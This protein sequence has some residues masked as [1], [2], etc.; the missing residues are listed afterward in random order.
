[1]FSLLSPGPSLLEVF[2]HLHQTWD[3]KN[4]GCAGSETSSCSFNIDSEKEFDVSSETDLTDPDPPYCR[5]RR[6][7]HGS[8]PKRSVP[9]LLP[10]FS[11]DSDDATDKDLS[12]IPRDYVQSKKPCFKGKGFKIVGKQTELVV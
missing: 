8:A 7:H 4:L 3:R 10:A 5:P 12:V 9:I 11:D 1:M 6:P 2:D